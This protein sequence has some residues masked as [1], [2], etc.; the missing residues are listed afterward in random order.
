MGEKIT[1][2][3]TV[4]EILKYGYVIGGVSPNL[5]DSPGKGNFI[6]KITRY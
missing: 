4:M 5:N 6:Q 1:D 2:N 3:E